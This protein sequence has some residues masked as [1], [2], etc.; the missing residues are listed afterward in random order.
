ML[1]LTVE[2]HCWHTTLRSELTWDKVKEDTVLSS[3]NKMFIVS[4]AHVLS[5]SK[6]DFKDIITRQASGVP[7][8]YNQRES[9]QK[10][11]I[12]NLL[13]TKLLF[14]SPACKGL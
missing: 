5:A 4:M 9:F 12:L 13:S 14:P 2:L 1:A 7:V 11:T 3:Y 8:R 10:Q 6:P